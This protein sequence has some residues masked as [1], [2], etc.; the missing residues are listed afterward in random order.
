[1]ILPS[2][3]RGKRPRHDPYVCGLFDHLCP[4]CRHEDGLPPLPDDLLRDPPA[5]PPPG[6]APAGDARDGRDGPPAPEGRRPRDARGHAG[7]V[8][9]FS[10]DMEVGP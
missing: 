1:M 4:G 10:F 2:H 9:R 8:R 5:T 3:R 6:R 7:R